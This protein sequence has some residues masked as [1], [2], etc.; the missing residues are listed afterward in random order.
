MKKERNIYMTTQ[1]D[2]SMSIKE[3]H[4]IN[5]SNFFIKGWY[6]SPTV[7]N[8]LI[9]YFKK[10]PDKVPGKVGKK[11]GTIG[12]DKTLKVSTDIPIH[13]SMQNPSNPPLVNYHR[14]LIK[15]L[16]LYFKKFPM[17][18]NFNGGLGLTEGWNIQ[19]Y[20]PK[21]GYLVYHQERGHIQNILRYLVFMT[22]LNDVKNGGETE[23]FHQQLKIKPKRGATFIFP[24]DWTYTHRGIPSPTETKYISTGWFSF[25]LNETQVERWHQ[26]H[27]PQMNV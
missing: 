27:S 5:K 12:T 18:Q 17:S 26:F 7:C 20:L 23:F 2:L 3:E 9:K 21:E 15:V 19:R 10:S 24:T 6:I 13:P 1:L 8:D 4:I 16:R 25:L 11:D 14:E 22:Y